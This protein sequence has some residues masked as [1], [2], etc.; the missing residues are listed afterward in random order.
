[1][2]LLWS[3]SEYWLSQTSGGLKSHLL[4]HR[5]DILSAIPLYVMVQTWFDTPFDGERH[6]RRIAKRDARAS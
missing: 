1:V 5:P 3:D 2:S 4:L 6:A